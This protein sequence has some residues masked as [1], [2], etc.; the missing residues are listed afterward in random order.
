MDLEL[1]RIT[2]LD[3][4]RPLRTFRK[5]KGSVEN[6][7]RSEWVF[8]THG[9]KNYLDIRIL[10]CENIGNSHG[11]SGSGFRK[12]ENLGRLHHFKK[13]VHKSYTLTKRGR[14]LKD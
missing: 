12:R 4:R 6:L 11:I 3:K 13:G 10:A 8:A 14:L 1:I 2:V 7:I 9:E 5:I